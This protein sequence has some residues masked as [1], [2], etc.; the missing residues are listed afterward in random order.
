MIRL[1]SKRVLVPTDFSPQAE[2]ALLEAFDLVDKPS[3]VT[4]L[5]VAPPLESYAVADPA[6]VWDSVSDEVRRERI[7]E[8]FLS[9][10][11]P[12]GKLDPRRK[13]VDFQVLFG[14][15]AEEIAK[16]A[17]DHH[18][19]MIMMPSH[20]RTGLRRLFVGSVA[21]RVVRTA[22]CPVLVLRD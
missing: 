16:F 10:P 19:D 9:T 12:D 7:A 21:E 3:D 18:F 14:Y 8:T 1:T 5:H 20:G 13:Q 15:P 17:Q 4:V 2:Q 22:H 11:G 6:I